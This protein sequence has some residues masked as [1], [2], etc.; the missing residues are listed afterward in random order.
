[1][2][3]QNSITVWKAIAGEHESITKNDRQIIITTS[4]LPEVQPSVTS[5]EWLFFKETKVAVCKL[6]V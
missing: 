1:M 5:H 3:L 2:L 6:S 4:M